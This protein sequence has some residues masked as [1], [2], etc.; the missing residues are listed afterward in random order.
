MKRFAVPIIFVL[1]VLV[2]L[3]TEKS[4]LFGKGDFAVRVLKDRPRAVELTWRDG[5]DAPMALRLEEAFRQNRDQAD[6][7]VLNLSSPGGSLREG[8]KVIDVMARM[9]QTH[10]VETIVKRGRICLSMCVPIFL[11]GQSRTAAANSRWMFH[12]PILMDMSGE[13]AEQPDFERNFTADRFFKRYFENSP[14][15][16]IWREQLR[17]DWVGRE[18]W[19]T[20]QDLV[21][22]RSNVVTDLL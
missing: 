1:L 9:A 17:E 6:I 3:Q 10:R 4:A 5:I 21:D 18:V 15:E 8:A 13:I 16:A 14:M 22:Q 11:Q 20:G 12:Q 7:F 2:A 19:F